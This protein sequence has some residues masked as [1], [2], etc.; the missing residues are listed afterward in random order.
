MTQA[1][2]SDCVA[3]MRGLPD[4]HFDLGHADP[5]YGIGE[6]T[7][8]NNKR[9]GHVKQKNGTRIWVPATD[10]G[11]EAW[12]QSPPGEE[13]FTELFRTCRQVILWGANYYDFPQKVTSSGL[14]VWNKGRRK[15]AGMGDAEVAWTNLFSSVRIVDYLW[16]GFQQGRS[17]KHPLAPRGAKADN[18]RRLQ[19]GHKPVLLYEI[20]IERFYKPG[21]KVF[22]SHLGSGSHR[23]A[24]ENLGV[25]FVGTEISP[26]RYARAEHR[27]HA[28]LS[29]QKLF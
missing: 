25:E 4:N 13:Y 18:E 21:W 12:D 5:P 27:F 14:I 24:C 29:V 19:N 8:A 20:M 7:A 3:Y 2:L 15:A 23:I 1:F 9:G 11:D 22:D 16:D 28:H 6:D 10:F 17:K 26:A